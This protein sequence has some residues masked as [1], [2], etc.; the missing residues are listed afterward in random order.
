MNAAT[1]AP[2]LSGPFC[3]LRHGETEPNRLGLVAGASNVPLNE[4]GWAQARAAAARLASGDID[5]IWC[6]PLQRARNTAR[7]VTE[8]LG[9]E[10]V[11]VAELAERNWG[12]LEGQ[13]RAL[14][15]RN[16][17]PPGG[18]SPE[19]FRLRTLI[20]LQQIGA[21]RMPLIVAHSGTFRV[22]G[23]WLDLP[24]Q[25]SPVPNSLPL[26]FDRSADGRWH[27]NAL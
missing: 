18:E 14:R 10:P 2:L 22:L 20:G 3:F 12:E 5:A 26:L 15:V 1:P 16:A 24:P 19:A 17:T 11:I 23:A 9:I 21:S 25:D 8:V 4:R 7:C 27:C 6:S 13:P